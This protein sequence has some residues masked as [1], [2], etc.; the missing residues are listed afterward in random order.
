MYLNQAIHGPSAYTPVNWS[1]N[2]CNKMSRQRI[3]TP[4]TRA[5]KDNSVSD[6]QTPALGK[7][8]VQNVSLKPLR[9]KYCP[10]Q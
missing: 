3:K 9:Q 4:E 8:R 5:L 6:A 10:S 2:L 1:E 7:Y